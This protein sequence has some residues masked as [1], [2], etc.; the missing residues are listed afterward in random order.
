LPPPPLLL[1][2]LL[3]LLPPLL[4]PLPPLLLAPLLLPE[5]EL[6]PTPDPS[7]DELGL[8]EQATIAAAAPAREIQFQT[9][10]RGY[11]LVF[12][13]PSFLHGRLP[14]RIDR[15]VAARSGEHRLQDG[16][17]SRDDGRE[18]GVCSR[19]AVSNNRAVADRALVRRR[20]GKT[21]VRPPVV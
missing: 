9:A 11:R 8:P 3:L 6:L 15:Q 7:G 18:H 10:V 19:P 13:E 5:L 17:S 1:P 14:R 20:S 16:D 2:P 12:T 21:R 4:L